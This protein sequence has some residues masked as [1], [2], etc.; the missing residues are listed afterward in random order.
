ML[1][2]KNTAKFVYHNT[3]IFDEIVY[4]NKVNKISI[5][6]RNLIAKN[7][8]YKDCHK[9]E[10]CFILGNGP[11][12]RE[13][14]FYK[15]KDEYV[16]TVNQLS[17]LDNFYELNTNYH[18]WSDERFFDLDAT[19]HE[20]M[21]LLEVMKKVKGKSNPVVFYKVFAKKMI[22]S[23]LLHDIL[24]ISYFDDVYIPNTTD[25]L[26]FVDYSKPV[27]VFP[28]VIHYL[29]CLSVYMGFKEIYL[30]GCDCTGFVSIA[31]NYMNGNNFNYSYDVSENE[32]KRMKRVNSKITI[33]EELA[34]Y[35]DIFAIYEKLNKYCR[36]NGVNLYNSTKGG[37][38]DCIS[39]KDIK[40]VLKK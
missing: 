18:M 12:I 13:L 34:W 29:I 5:E 2:L 23:Y 9:G 37:L 16:F 6:D 35:A 15:L 1:S 11:S 21:E 7:T 26:K 8:V 25:K 31:N 20:D 39:R 28:T 22:D 36:N 24:N 10:R 19:R 38:L 33:S 17:R 14:D 3:N 32:K 30:L 4:R 40:T 27:P